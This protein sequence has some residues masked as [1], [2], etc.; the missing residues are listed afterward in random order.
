MI[1]QQS[2]LVT[3]A[4]F[5]RTASMSVAEGIMACERLRD[6]APIV[7]YSMLIDSMVEKATKR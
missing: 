6:A 7:R 3:R 2:M 5:G 1:S 4:A